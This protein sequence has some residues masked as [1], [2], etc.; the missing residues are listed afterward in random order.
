MSDGRV[1][2]PVA[3]DAMGGDDA[4]DAVVRGARRA[5]M[6]GLPVVLVGDPAA[7]GEASDLPVVAA[8]DVL[9][10]DASPHQVRVMEGASVRVAARL[11]AAG[12][13]GALVSCGS[14]GASVVS[15]VLDLGLLDGVDR[16]AIVAS[17]PT[18]NGG[19]VHVLDVGASLDLRP[20]QLAQLATLGD[21]WAQVLGTEA[22]RIGLLSNGTER[23]KGPRA[24][25]DAWPLIE[26]LPVRFVGAV[27][28][29][30]ALAGEVDVLVTEGFAGNV[31]LKTAEGVVGMLGALLG[32][33]LRADGLKP[34]AD[35][36]FGD[37]FARLRL[38]LDWRSRG[39]A[40]LL[41]ARAP[42]VI[43]HGRA[44]ADAVFAAIRLAHYA[45]AQRL[46]E[47]VAE[48]I[49]LARSHAGE[50]SGK[51]S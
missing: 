49:R 10:M 51:G 14:S 12:E 19:Q 48:R 31:L 42:V 27:E 13:A 24:V 33:E 6:A 35:R 37:V 32:A 40:V 9:P 25:R 16:P 22:P 4:P 39:G 8:S 11:V 21:A 7:L 50:G 2:L 5:A 1:L 29:H 36:V 20:E 44:D 34:E 3:V 17:L 47:R 28:P 26:A 45:A 41:G 30:A 38:R 18:A 15:A 43:G 23:H 46:P